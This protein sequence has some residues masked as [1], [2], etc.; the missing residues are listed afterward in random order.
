MDLFRS[1]DGNLDFGKMVAIWDGGLA[2]YGGIIAGILVAFLY[3]RHNKIRFGA[4]TDLAALGLFLGQSI[5]R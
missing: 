2:I 3:A 1:A 5:G 4:L